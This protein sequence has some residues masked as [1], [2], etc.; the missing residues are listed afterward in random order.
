M[1]MKLD[2]LKQ[3]YEEKSVYLVSRCF[4]DLEA[5]EVQCWRKDK[6]TYKCNLL[7]NSEREVGITIK[8]CQEGDFHPDEMVLQLLNLYML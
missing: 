3:K 5:L 7:E 1:Y 6:Y 8:A 2:L 4:I